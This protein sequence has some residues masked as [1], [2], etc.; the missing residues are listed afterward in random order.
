MWF[1]Y[2]IYFFLVLSYYISIKYN[3]QQYT[4]WFCLVLLTFISGFRP[5]EC[6]SD[7]S[8]YVDYYDNIDTHSFIELEPTFFLISSISK[9][10]FNSSIGVFL[11]YAVIGVLSK[12]FAIKKL[13]SLYLLSLII[14]S[15][16]FFLLHEMTQIRVGIASSILLLSIPSIYERKKYI[17]LF[18]ILLGTL[19]H[20]S[21]LIFGL[22]YF[23]QPKTLNP[24]LYL[25]LIAFG[26]ISY[27][28]GINIVSMATLIPIEFISSKL[29]AYNKLLEMGVDTKINV[30]NILVIFRI[31]FLLVLLWKNKFLYEK[32]KYALVLIKIYAFSI[33]LFT[34]L[35]TLP[36]LAFRI[37]ELLGIVEIIL[38]PFLIYL[39]KEKHIAFIIFLS[40]GL[41]LMSIDIW[42][43]KI[44]F[45]YF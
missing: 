15:S 8:T 24:Y 1:Y 23:V 35:S 17:F 11:I 43:N 18:F 2:A 38:L 7:Y 45:N 25:G 10:I 32:N 44:I 28:L 30:F 3:I 12:G 40:I 14:Y 26:F 13:S 19:F 22:F 27:L 5:S 39:I 20:Y 33:F 4:F 42:Y 31:C 16:T 36:V 21:F 9:V 34:F 37:R 6:C 29:I 41:M